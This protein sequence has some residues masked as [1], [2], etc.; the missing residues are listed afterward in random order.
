[1]S[2]RKAINLK[3]RECIYDPMAEGTWR[4]QISACTS[5]DCPLYPHRPTSQGYA[6]NRA[7]SVDFGAKLDGLQV[8]EVER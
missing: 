4:Q 5:P 8:L 1:M 2:L 6:A 3:C 7:N